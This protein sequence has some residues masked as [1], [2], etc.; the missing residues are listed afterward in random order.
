MKRNQQ[1]FQINCP[2]LQSNPNCEL[3]IYY[4]SKTGID[5]ALKHC[6]HCHSCRKF[7]PPDKDGLFSNQR[8]CSNQQCNKIITYSSKYARKRTLDSAF[9]RSCSAKKQLNQINNGEFPEHKEKR[10]KSLKKYYETHDHWGKGKKRPQHVIDALREAAKNRVIT[11]EYRQKMSDS[12]TGERNGFYGKHHTQETLDR[13]QETR[14]KNI[15]NGK[16]I[17]I[18]GKTQKYIT[19]DGVELMMKSSWEV[20]FAKFLDDFNI[21]WLYE[22]FHYEILIENKIR[23]YTLDFYFPD[24]NEW[25]EIKGRWF[26]HSKIKHEAFLKQYPDIKVFVF[27]R[28]HLKELNVL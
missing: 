18:R 8:I 6:V 2:N 15:R 27:I 5:Y 28:D 1:K 11:D 12:Q 17:K 21:N 10:K 3:I 25:V 23:T 4:D 9:C 7:D 14:L 22:P 13:I 26:P 20:K 19:R 16:K 24:T